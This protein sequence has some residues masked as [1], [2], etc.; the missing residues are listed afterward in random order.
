MSK[1]VRYVYVLRLENDNWYVGITAN[2]A[3]RLKAHN[4][5]SATAWTTLHR[6]IQEIHT[7]PGDRGIENLFTV[8][9]AKHF[10]VD[11]VRGGDWAQP[12]LSERR[13]GKLIKLTTLFLSVENPNLSALAAILAA[14]RSPCATN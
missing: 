3:N 2:L 6:V 12:E 8:F 5:G 9:L 4:R 13:L 10:G 14:L 7:C 1:H 11:H